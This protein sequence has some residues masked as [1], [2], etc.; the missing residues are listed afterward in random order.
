MFVFMTT[1][2]SAINVLTHPSVKRFELIIAGFLALGLGLTARANDFYVSQSGSGTTNS[3]AW[4]NTPTSWNNGAGTIQAGDTVHL[5]GTF[6]NTL[7]LGGGGAP[8]NPVTIYFESGANFTLSAG[9]ATAALNLGANNYVTVDGGGAG[10]IAYTDN[11]T[12]KTYQ[13]AASGVVSLPSVGNITV[14]NLTITNVFVHTKNTTNDLTDTYGAAIYV[15]ASGTGMTNISIYNC[16]ISEAQKGVYITYIGKT[17]GNW[18]IYSNI[19][20][21]CSWGIA[22]GDQFGNSILSGVLIYGNRVNG[23]G[24]WDTPGNIFH[25]N[26]VYFW[27]EIAGSYVT[28]VTA[29]G[30]FFG[31]DLGVNSTAAIFLSSANGAGI[32]KTSI[33]DNLFAG[34][35]PANGMVEVWNGYVVMACNNTTVS[36]TNGS[37]GFRFLTCSNV[38][39]LNNIFASTSV[40]VAISDAD[41]AKG[42]TCDYNLYFNLNPWG[43]SWGIG[44][45]YSWAQ[46]KAAGNDLHSLYEPDPL[47]VDAN[48]YNFRLQSGSPAIGAGPNLSGIF[49]TDYAGNPRPSAGG[50]T[51]GAYEAATIL[52]PA[53]VVSLTASLTNI[54]AGASNAPQFSKLS[55]TSA[56]T[57]NLVLSSIGP[58]SLTGSTNVSP[59]QDTT[60]TITAKGAN[61]TNSASVSIM[62]G[63]A[64]PS[65][66]HPQ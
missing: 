65:Q 36:A 9:V 8:G 44:A 32:Y 12:A 47:F 55:W 10:L 63:P 29:Y 48:N 5:V 25:E 30:N 13:I 26:G 38:T 22:G 53:P 18:N 4:L 28:N 35:S 42:F 15:Q 33:Y 62:V 59:S 61:G 31:P 21:N 20:K 64:P 45:N 23:L 50:W 11:G 60:Y 46:W 24:T 7:T 1:L 16:N 3:L 49:T 58:V 19:I 37:I 14:R 51:I 56:N 40:T 66:L 43:G 27:A 54:F 6:T 57:T 17:N 52:S 34:P 39:V 41:M 2:R